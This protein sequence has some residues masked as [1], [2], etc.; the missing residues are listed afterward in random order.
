MKR[1]NSSF[2]LL[3]FFFVLILSIITAI[4]YLQKRSTIGIAPSSRYGSESA[5]PVHI[6]NV[7]RGGG[8]DGHEMTLARGISVSDSRYSMAPEASRSWVAPPDLRDVLIPPGAIPININTQGIPESYQSMGVIRM[9]EGGELLPLY[10]R[11]NGRGSDIYN[12]YTRTDTY[13]PV[14]IPISFGRRDCT[15]DNG[16]KELSDGD[17]VKVYGK[18]EGSVKLYGIGAPK[19]IPGIV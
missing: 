1:T 10:G 5:P 11:R 9:G 3:L 19:Y 7:I 8:G 13:N 12:Y 15:D 4:L 6:T 14:Q 2:G 17:S 18:G 16:C